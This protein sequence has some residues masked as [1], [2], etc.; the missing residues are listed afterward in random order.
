M[1]AGEAGEQGRG[2]ALGGGALVGCDDLVQ[3][4]RAQ[5]AAQSPVDGVDAEARLA[6]RIAPAGTLSWQDGG[7]LQA[8]DPAAKVGQQAFVT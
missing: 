3:A 5:A 8:L 1:R 6:P 2:E 7:T 4:G